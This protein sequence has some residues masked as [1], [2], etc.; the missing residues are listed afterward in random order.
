M[1]KLTAKQ[2]RFCE[3]YVIDLNGAQAAIRAG[4][5]ENSAKEIAA[6]NLTKP[7]ISNYIAMLQK[8]IEERNQIRADDVVKE[9]AKIGFMSI[10]ELFDEDN[11]I[12]AVNKLSDKAKASVSS[13]K[14]TKKSYGSEEEAVFETTTEMKLWDKRAALVDL[15]KHL[16]IFEAD[17]KQKTLVAPVILDNIPKQ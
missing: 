11:K 12:K 2:K 10:D 4:Y 8:E 1:C 9:L 3:E 5:S 14:I 13:V 16:G 7:N 6:E 17:N 15:G